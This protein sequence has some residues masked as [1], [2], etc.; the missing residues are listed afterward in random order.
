MEHLGIMGKTTYKVVQ[1]FSHQQY[2]CTTDLWDGNVYQAISPKLH[3]AFFHRNHVGK[4]ASPMDPSWVYIYIYIKKAISGNVDVFF[5]FGTK[6]L[7]KTRSFLGR[8][9]L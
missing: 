7:P 9:A 8:L 3:V 4:Y 6:G 1:D 2:Y 5:F